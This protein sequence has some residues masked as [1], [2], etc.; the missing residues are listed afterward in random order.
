MVV[1]NVTSQVPGTEVDHQV[2]TT[3]TGTEVHDVVLREV[4]RSVSNGEMETVL[5]PYALR[6]VP[7]GR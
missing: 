6:R 1:V 4:R 3:P 2:Q 7:T 5:K